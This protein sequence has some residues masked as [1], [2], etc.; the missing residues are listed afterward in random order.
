MCWAWSE[1]STGEVSAS[2][3][4]FL[5]LI[6][7][8]A[9][10]FCHSGAKDRICDSVDDGDDVDV[11]VDVDV[12]GDVGVGDDVRGDVDVGDGVLGKLPEATEKSSNVSPSCLLFLWWIL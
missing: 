2:S 11:R 7:P 10:V 5:Y 1:L 12:G 8:S 6:S 9:G 4:V 3:K